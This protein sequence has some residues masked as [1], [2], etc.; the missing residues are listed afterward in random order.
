MITLL[1]V[2]R[3]YISDDSISHTKDRDS[4]N[5][6]NSIHEELMSILQPDD[7]LD[8]DIFEI[9]TDVLTHLLQDLIKG[10]SMM[11]LVNESQAC[12]SAIKKLT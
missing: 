5:L 7:Y 2:Q 9:K 11:T 12:S 3:Q 6:L 10:S 8:P 1:E 4:E